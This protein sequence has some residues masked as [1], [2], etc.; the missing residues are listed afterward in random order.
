MSS[1]EELL[2][3]IRSLGR[4]TRGSTPAILELPDSTLYDIFEQMKRGLS[5]RAIARHL[6]KCGMKGS[7][8]SL[9][10]SVSLFHK[11]IAPLLGAESTPPSLPR[12]PVKLPAGV[13]SLPP[14]ERLS[15]L[16]AIVKD[17][18]EY[19]RQQT[20]AAARK[21]GTIGEDVAK[22]AKAYSTLLAT[23]ARLEA[24]VMKSRP[25]GQAEDP[26]F[27]ERADRAWDQLTDNG[28]DND[29]MAKIVDR[30]LMKLEKRC[31]SLEQDSTG[32]W[33]EAPRQ[34]PGRSEPR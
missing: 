28:R 18:G 20:E 12:S 11:R 34:R 17:Y 19:I 8:N 23:Q 26:S 14:D 21:G 29:S 25:V 16:R 10:Q 24:T 7:E 30:F 9:Q 15:T 5:N 13:S 2:K 22:H 1:R 31:I 27:K 32:Q 33:H 6:S 3:Q 4:G